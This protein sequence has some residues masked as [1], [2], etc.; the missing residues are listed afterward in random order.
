MTYI[1]T[2]KGF[3]KLYRVG[4]TINTHFMQKKTTVS[5][6]KLTLKKE[7]MQNLIPDSLFY[8]KGGVNKKEV[9]VTIGATSDHCAS[10]N[11]G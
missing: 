10:H 4:V 9:T 1:F 2:F 3:R 8:I 11:C 5:E 6:R 7:K